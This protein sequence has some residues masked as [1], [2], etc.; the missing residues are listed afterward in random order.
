MFDEVREVGQGRAKLVTRNIEVIDT[1]G[2]GYGFHSISKGVYSSWMDKSR[3]LSFPSPLSILL[4]IL[5]SS[6]ALGC[7]SEPP[8]ELKI[9]PVPGPYPWEI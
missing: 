2:I 7:P 3:L 1:G 6:P 5:N 4:L 8:G 9:I